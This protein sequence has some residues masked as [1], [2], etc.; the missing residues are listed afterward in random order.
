MPHHQHDLRTGYLAR[1]LQGAIDNVELGNLTGL[2]AKIRPAVEAAQYRGE[3]S[4]K[5]MSL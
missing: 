2:L 3:R 4:A 1:E 5:I